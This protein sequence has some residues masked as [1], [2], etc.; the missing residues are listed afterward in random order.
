MYRTYLAIVGN[1]SVSVY[2]MNFKSHKANCVFSCLIC[3]YL[4]QCSSPPLEKHVFVWIIPRAC[5]IWGDY[6]AHRVHTS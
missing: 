1:K 2:E 6:T 4:W 3:E 5:S